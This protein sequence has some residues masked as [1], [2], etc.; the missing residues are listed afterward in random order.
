MCA[1]Y[2]W[3]ILHKTNIYYVS[4]FGLA[5][6]TLIVVSSTILSDARA[7]TEKNR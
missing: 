2:T 4:L 6:L 1:P 5:M 7:V 3:I